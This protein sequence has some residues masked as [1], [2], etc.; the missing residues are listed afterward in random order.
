MFVLLVSPFI[1]TV[2]PLLFISFIL[3]E[4]LSEAEW[5]RLTAIAKKCEYTRPH[6][7]STN[8]IAVHAAFTERH[9]LFVFK[10]PKPVTTRSCAF[11]F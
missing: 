6:C 7:P 1:H 2:S 8:A 3:G 10:P 5:D 4:K 9:A 11:L